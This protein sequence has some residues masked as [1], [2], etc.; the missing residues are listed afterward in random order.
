MK[1]IFFS[2]ILIF[3]S[4]QIILADN[5]YWAGTETDSTAVA[6]NTWIFW[7]CLSVTEI[8]KWEI[9]IE[10]IPC[11]ITS[12]INILMWL[13]WT[14]S[15]VF[16]IYWAYQILLW[17]LDSDKS[18][19]KNTIIAAIFGFIIASLAWFIIRLIIDNLTF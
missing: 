9:H 13:A 17:S 6:G 8:R 15:V 3:L 2:I 12:V 10:Q 14:I 16:I 5:A 18:K 4:L 11:I 1:K 19:W 7:G